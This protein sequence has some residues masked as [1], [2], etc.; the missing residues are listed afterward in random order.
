MQIVLFMSLIF[1]SVMGPN[2]Q[3]WQITL[4]HPVI[5]LGI[6][7]CRHVIE[8]SLC[9]HQDAWV[10]EHFWATRE[11]HERA[12]ER[13][14]AEWHITTLNKL[15]RMALRCKILVWQ[16][17]G[18]CQTLK[19]TSMEWHSPAEL[20]LTQGKLERKMHSRELSSSGSYARRAETDS[21]SGGGGPPLS[22]L[23]R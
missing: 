16:L 2:I 11:R 9:M 6:M 15:R 19:D 7:S 21:E 22:Q 10:L 14:D 23:C 12:D 20:H 5:H 1:K 8:S 4:A 18:W 17:H 13:R 3:R